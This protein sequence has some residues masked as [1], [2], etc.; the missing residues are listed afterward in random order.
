MEP[1]R[2]SAHVTA[3]AALAEKLAA[4]GVTGPS[5]LAAMAQVPRHCFIGSELA[6]LAYQDR[7][8]PIARSQTI[9]QPFVVAT[10][11]QLA[12]GGRE[13]LGRVLEIGTGS[14]YQSAVLAA[15][16]DE[17]YSV[18]RIEPLHQGAAAA[19]RG[20]GVRNVRLRCAD[21]SAGWPE[22]APFDAV[23]VTAAAAVVES[24]WLDQLAD[25]GVLVV[26]LGRAMDQD[27]VEIRKEGGNVTR[28]AI[29]PVL[30]VPLLEGIQD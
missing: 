11:T 12:L 20:A 5:V 19:L 10:M 22:A 27:L 18:E 14:G 23:V 3:R 7:A 16:A 21:G 1:D 2:E 24:A 9:S 25:P 15:V 29:F 13:R 8:L 30:F 6:H 26:P 28:R 17:V 4:R